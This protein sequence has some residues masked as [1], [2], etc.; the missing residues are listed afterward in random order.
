MRYCVLLSLLILLT[1]CATPKPIIKYETVTVYQDRYI[2][3]PDGLTQG[4]EIVELPE[5][6][7]GL[8]LGIAYK[9]QVIRAKECNAR[10]NEIRGL[11]NGD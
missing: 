2:A 3:V 8:S 9:A 11:G 1:G 6:V 7:D 10:M 5:Q 4:C